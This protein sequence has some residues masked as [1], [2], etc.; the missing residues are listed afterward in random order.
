M[1]KIQDDICVKIYYEKYTNFNKSILFNEH[2]VPV[3][4]TYKNTDNYMKCF[5]EKISQDG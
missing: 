1:I 5:R 2:L 3:F 4:S